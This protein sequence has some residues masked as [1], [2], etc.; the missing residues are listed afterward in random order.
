MKNFQF[1]MPTRIVFGSGELNNLHKYALPGKKALLVIS[2][3]KS[4]K[5]NGYL[6]LQRYKNHG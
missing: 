6:V 4:T 2:K 3:G 1:Y 5:E